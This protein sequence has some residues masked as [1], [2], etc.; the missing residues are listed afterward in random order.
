MKRLVL[1][2][3]GHSHVE[4]IRRFG[5][6]P[7]TDLSISLI[8]PGRFT[9]Y[10][11]ML[12]GLVAGHYEFH[13]CH[14]DL[15]ALTQFARIDFITEKAAQLDLN[16][17]IVLS[18]TGQRY[19]FDLLSIDIGSTPDCSMPGAKQYAAPVKPVE[20]LLSAWQQEIEQL[21]AR[22]GGS[23]AVVGGGAGG[24]EIL[25]AMHYRVQ[26]AL[27]EQAE[28]VSF[29]LLTDAADILPRFPRRVREVFKRILQH[30]HVHVHT[31]HAVIGIEPNRILRRNQPPLLID[32]V[33]L[34]TQACAAPW[35]AA[36][37]LATD[38]HGFVLVDKHLQSISHPHIF[39]AGDIASLDCPKSG[40]YAVKQGPVLAHNLRARMSGEKLQAF[41]PQKNSLALI[42]TGDRH[43][44]ATRGHWILQGRW[45]WRWK[46][47]IDRRFMAKYRLR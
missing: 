17:N 38:Q 31:E 7:Q 36:S 24:V 39:A 28:N 11:G 29:H 45:V 41:L 27:A 5:L 4:V 10:S 18:D 42:S 46:D 14:I 33:I 32:Y 9:P 43:A 15:Q 26:R 30:K 19:P 40:V 2:G 47:W 16:N 23:V 8:S 1:L 6:N 25:L 20:A 37:G 12:P 3:G 13:D 34:A 21:K 35:L 22:H 44:V